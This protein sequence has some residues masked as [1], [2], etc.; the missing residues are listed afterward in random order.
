MADTKITALTAISTVDPAVDVLPIVDVSDTTMAASGTTKKIT[1]NQILGAGGTAT[2]AS[3]TI[4]G[5][6]TVDTSTLKVDSANDKVGFGTTSPFTRADS[7]SS[8]NTALGSIAAFNTMPLSVT[9]DT[10][11]AIGVGGGLNFRAKLTSSTYST[12]AGIWSYR[13]NALNSDYAGSLIF[14]T[15]DNSNG[16]PIERFRI[17]SSGVATWSVGGSTAMTLN[18][19]GLGVGVTPSAGRLHIK[20]GASQSPLVLDTLGYNQIVLQL[21]GANRGQIYADATNCFALVDSTGSNSRLLVTDSGNVGVGVTPSAWSSPY[22]SIE[23]DGG[24]LSVYPTTD[25]Y[26]SQ[27]AVNVGGWK[28]KATGF[29]SQYI[30]VNSQHRWQI[31]ASGTA[32]NAITF[33]QA[34]T[35]DASGNLLVGT[36]SGSFGSRL[37]ISADSGTTSWATGPLAAAPLNYYITANNTQGV[38]LNGTSATAWTAIS[39]ERFKDIIEPITNAVSKVGSLRSVIGKFKTDAEGTRRSFLIAQDVLAAF[40]EAAVANNPDKL[41]VTY[42]EVIPLLVAA[43]KELTARVEALEA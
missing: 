20:G 41:G 17:S 39:D 12:Y 37:I 4:S 38:F 34:M 35:L 29:A 18:S 8:R 23:L 22:K 14:G 5:D 40:P 25:F 31:A 26:I 16:Y 24:N 32:G 19:T 9:D 7:L 21:N 2:L 1:S 27:N 11:F 10:A 6:L 28:Y 36:T 13:E 15:S 33:T 30:Q 43:I 42:T 3:A